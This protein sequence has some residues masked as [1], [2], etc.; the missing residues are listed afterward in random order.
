MA[1]VMNIE[2]LSAKIKVSVSK[3]RK[4]VMRKEIPHTKIGSR[5]VF[6][7][8]DIEKWLVKQSVS[9]GSLGLEKA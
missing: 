5:V 7:D 1:V 9:S 3:I 4:L 2:E 8:A 6:I